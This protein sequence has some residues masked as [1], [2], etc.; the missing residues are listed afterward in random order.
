MKRS[1]SQHDYLAGEG[2][3]FGLTDFTYQ[4]HLTEH[5]RPL[6]LKRLTVSVMELLMPV[7]KVESGSRCRSRVAAPDVVELSGVAE[8]YCSYKVAAPLGWCASEGG[9][10]MS[11]RTIVLSAASVIIDIARIAAVSTVTFGRPTVERNLD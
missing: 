5:A 2:T 11:P 7:A 6:N 3:S 10:V 4:F 8:Q 9:L 1:T